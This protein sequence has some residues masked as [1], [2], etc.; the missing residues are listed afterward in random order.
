MVGAARKR[1]KKRG[2]NKRPLLSH[3]CWRHA[4]RLH[5]R[6]GCIAWCILPVSSYHAGA[7]YGRLDHCGSAL[8][9]TFFA[10]DAEARHCASR[11]VRRHRPSVPGCFLLF[12]RLP[13]ATISTR[14]STT[15]LPCT[16]LIFCAP[17][18]LAAALP[19]FSSPQHPAFSIPP[20]SQY[21]R[22]RRQRHRGGSAIATAIAMAAATAA[23]AAAEASK[24]A[25]VCTGAWPN[26]FEDS[27]SVSR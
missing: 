20:V 6:S 11:G 16:R 7:R 10:A 23:A 1:E 9:D 18:H 3:F 17:P 12:I 13:Q 22:R 4:R 24:E 2:R 21:Y 5:R 26:C 27:T 25:V 8:A 19:T 15:H 14:A